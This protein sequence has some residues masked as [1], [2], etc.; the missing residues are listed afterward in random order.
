MVAEPQPVLSLDIGGTKLAVAVVTS[1]GTPHGLLIEPTHR[2]DGP[3]VILGRLLAMG[4]Q[5]IQGAGLGPVAAVGISCG[6][7]LDRVAGVLTGPLH[8]PGWIDIPIVDI[9]ERE[10]GVPVALDNDATAAALG[11]FRYGSGRG[12]STMLYLT[13][14]T[15]IGGGAVINRQL[16]RGGAQ[17][18]GEY[19]HILVETGGRQCLCG[20]RGCLEVYASGSS[21]AARAREAIDAGAP[22]TLG[23]LA[24][25]RAED[26]SSHAQAG[27]P[28]AR[29]LWD[30]TTALLASAITDLVNILE[31]DLVVLG[32]GVTRSG[33]FLLDPIADA[34]TH[35]S[36]PP[37]AKVVR[38]SLAELGDVVCVI[39]AAAIAFALLSETAEAVGAEARR[40]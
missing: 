6:G 31:P 32:G 23:D 12:T 35:D 1:D 9:V 40:G 3:D 15:G 38:V 37:A 17:N 20:R 27:D 2:D 34:V 24:V 29:E 28:L 10:F 19:G 21:I 11:E 5:S 7:P 8:L 22:S 14:S 36:M 18:G 26:V 4:Q 33:R 30:H 13:I 25:V 39:G 16:H